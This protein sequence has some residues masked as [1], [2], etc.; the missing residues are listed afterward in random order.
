MLFFSLNI[1][2]STIKNSFHD[3]FSYTYFFI[4]AFSFWKIFFIFFYFISLSSRNFILCVY[5]YFLLWKIKC[6]ESKRN[7]LHR[8]WSNKFLLIFLFSISIPMDF[9]RRI[10]QWIFHQLAHESCDV[11]RIFLPKWNS[12]YRVIFGNKF[13]LYDKRENVWKFNNIFPSRFEVAL[14]LIIIMMRWKEL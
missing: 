4:L 7:S 6:T 3:F 1:S 2:L 13:K 10:S 12:R 8:R 5:V 9:P 11:E 14:I